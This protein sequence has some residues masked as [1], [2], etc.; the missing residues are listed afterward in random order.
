MNKRQQ[1]VLIGDPAQ[2]SP[3]L[4]V[5]TPED[6]DSNLPQVKQLKETLFH[7]LQKVLPSYF[8][9]QQYRMHPRIA[10]FPSTIL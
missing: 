8:L 4:L 10:E 1:L 5:C 2:L 3:T 7:H 9:N 6:D